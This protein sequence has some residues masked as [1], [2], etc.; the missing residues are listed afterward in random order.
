MIVILT[1]IYFHWEIAGIYTNSMVFYRHNNASSQDDDDDD[2]NDWSKVRD[3]DAI[4]IG[5]AHYLY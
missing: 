2:K 5:Q 1:L 4:A 3:K